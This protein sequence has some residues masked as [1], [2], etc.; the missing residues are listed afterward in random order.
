L[1]TVESYR[2]ELGL[3]A[4]LAVREPLCLTQPNITH[5]KYSYKLRGLDIV[6]AN[7]VWST[8]ITYIKI[9]G[10]MVY[11]AAVIDWHF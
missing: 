8:D 10:G 1:T 9:A 6:R 4:V 2:K 7:Q 3:R 11:L 5:P